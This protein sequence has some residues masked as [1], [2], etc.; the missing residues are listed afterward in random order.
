MSSNMINRDVCSH[1]TFVEVWV[2]IKLSTNTTKPRIFF[3]VSLKLRMIVKMHDG[4]MPKESNRSNNIARLFGGLL[5]VDLYYKRG[6]THSLYVNP[7]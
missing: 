3:Y 4:I 7:M 5:K 1:L 2:L 6:L